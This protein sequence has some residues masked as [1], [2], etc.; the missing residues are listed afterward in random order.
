MLPSTFVWC[1]ESLEVDTVTCVLLAFLACPLLVSSLK[2]SPNWSHAGFI[3]VSLEI[4]CLKCTVFSDLQRLFNI[5]KIPAAT[6]NARWATNMAY[7]QHSMDAARIQIQ[8]GMYFFFEHP[9]RASSWQQ[10]CVRAILAMDGVMLVTFDRA[11]E[12]TLPPADEKTDHNY[13]EL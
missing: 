4:N 2:N 12:Q 9:A 11:E 1:I 3:L 10:A 13:D 7:L 6:W 8:R 5:R